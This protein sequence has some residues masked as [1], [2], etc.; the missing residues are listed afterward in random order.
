MIGGTFK[1]IIAVLLLAGSF[2]SALNIEY[3]SS[4][5]TGSGSNAL[6]AQFQSNGLCHDNC[7]AQFAFAIV[8]GSSCWCSNYVPFDT[9]TTTLC[10]QDCP[11]FPS[12]KCGNTTAGFFG[13]IA[14]SVQPSGTQGAPSSSSSSSTAAASTVQVTVPVSPSPVTVLAT[15]TASPSVYTTIVSIQAPPVVQT[16]IVSV[17]A[18]PSVQ[19]TFISVQVSPSTIFFTVSVTIASETMTSTF[20]LTTSTV[21]TATIISLT[22]IFATTTSISSSSPSTTS[23][24]SYSTP[25]STPISTSTI[26]S[27][28]SSGNLPTMLTR[29][30]TSWTPTPYASVTTITDGEILTVTLTPTAP[31]PARTSITEVDGS[32]NFWAT[33]SKVVPTFVCIG[34]AVI[35]AVAGFLWYCH[36]KNARNS[37]EDPPILTNPTSA[38]AS[39]PASMMSKLGDA[40]GMTGMNRARSNRSFTVNRNSAHMSTSGMEM[41]HHADRSATNFITPITRYDRRPTDDRLDPAAIHILRDDDAAST[42]SFHDERDYSR[43]IL[44]DGRADSRPTLIIRNPDDD[45]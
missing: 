31:P 24:T 22:S 40:L 20:S 37:L 28:T 5:N 45:E 38:T 26:S 17:K 13:Y 11:G 43:R 33:T 44:P 14:L 30:S 3:C 34:L 4:E 9:T 7:L 8:Q 1:T 12:D 35:A 21:A 27:S 16:T 18:S 15:V 32:R 25:T 2:V 23:S 42:R 29:S 19:T 39:R 41:T 36:R 10:G 6:T